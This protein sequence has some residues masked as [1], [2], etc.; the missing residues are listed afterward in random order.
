VQQLTIN[1]RYRLK[2]AALLSMPDDC[3]CLVISCHGFRGAKENSGKIYGF[4]QK[5]HQI[6]AG[7]LAFDFQGSGESQGHYRSITLARQAHD[8]QDVINYADQQFKLPII[9]LGR[10]FGGSTV[11]AGASQDS[12]VAGYILWST[13]VFL[14]ET[15]ASMDAALASQI[16]KGETITLT[17]EGGTYQLDPDLFRDFDNHNMDEYLRAIGDRPVLIVHGD[18]D[19]V[20][21]P[22]N[23]RYI[24]RLLPE[25]QLHIVKGADH[26]FTQ[27]IAL[28]EDLTIRWLASHWGKAAEQ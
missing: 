14:K 8:L 11:L 3:H 21:N 24:A 27:Q 13:P 5:L 18:S 28:R 22:Q 6:G 7:L 19:E 1:N 20:V 10:S 16:E 25:A 12:R 26:R 4:G 2:L 15:F 23:A 9:A 17:D